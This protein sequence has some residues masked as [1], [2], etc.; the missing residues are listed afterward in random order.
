M[1][2]SNRADIPQPEIPSEDHATVANVIHRETLAFQ[3]KDFAH[4]QQYWLQTEQT[5]DVF[6]SSTAGLNVFR[7]WKEVAANMKKFFDED[8]VTKVLDFGQD[9]M[10]VSLS[11]DT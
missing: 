7:G 5:Q 10:R 4:W 6:F 1:N 11:G 2:E 8:P 3:Q 9:N